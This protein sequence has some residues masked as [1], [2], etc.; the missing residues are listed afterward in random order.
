MTRT[1]III[2]II[3]AIIVVPLAVYTVSPLFVSTEVNEPLPVLA[4]AEFQRFM[5]LTED[6]RIQAADNMSKQEKDSIMITAAKENSTVNESMDANVAR[7]E[8]LCSK[9]SCPEIL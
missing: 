3:I 9:I 4:S 8:L 6:G 7:Q 1:K 5:N 2:G